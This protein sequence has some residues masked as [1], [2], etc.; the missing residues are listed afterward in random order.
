MHVLVKGVLIHLCFTLLVMY[1]SSYQQHQVS[2]GSEPV[3]REICST[4]KHKSFIK[5]VVP[6]LNSWRN[7]SCGGLMIAVQSN[8]TMGRWLP[9]ISHWNG[10]CWAWI[11]FSNSRAVL[12]SS[13]DH[14]SSQ[15][16]KQSLSRT[17]S[18]LSVDVA[19][20][21]IS[22]VSSRHVLCCTCMHVGRFCCWVPIYRAV[23]LP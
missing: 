19:C 14:C 15:K 16:I 10:Y 5:P 3:R 8:W 13:Q 11:F 7:C 21:V 1:T 23:V 6:S 2:H 12:P 18:N 22:E 9:D 20:V 4:P 17:I